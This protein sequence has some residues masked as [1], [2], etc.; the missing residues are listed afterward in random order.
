MASAGR[1]GVAS[2]CGCCRTH[3]S[4]QPG[5]SCG[6]GGGR[7]RVPPLVVLLVYVF[8]SLVLDPL[9]A[10]PFTSSGS[11]VLRF[12]LFAWA[13][14]FPGLVSIGIA[15]NVVGVVAG[16]SARL[17]VD[18]ICWRDACGSVLGQADVVQ[19][20]AGIRMQ[21]L[22]DGI[23]LREGAL[24]VGVCSACG[25]VLGEPNAVHVAAG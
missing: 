2:A 16:I 1:V 8:H 19:V 3:R 14:P 18:G 17:R 7:L 5:P 9:A 24:V 12:D 10:V 6:C 4:S 11:F 22:V 20:V 13:G 21:L 25:S 15:C 23:C